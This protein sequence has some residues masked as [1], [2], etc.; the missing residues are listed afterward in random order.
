MEH[1]FCVEVATKHGIEKAIILKNLE[2]WIRKN[3]ANNKHYH[4]G[5]FWTYNSYSAFS[6]LFPYIKE[7]RIGNILRE[8]EVEGLIK[9]GNYNK[10][11]YDRTKWYSI[12]SLDFKQKLDLSNK[13]I[14][15]NPKSDNGN[16]ESGR[17]IPDNKP[18]NKHIK[19]QHVHEDS[20]NSG[21][22]AS[23][24]KKNNAN[25]TTNTEVLSI[26]DQIISLRGKK[27][28]VRNKEGFKLILIRDYKKNPSQLKKWTDEILI[29]ESIAKKKEAIRKRDEDEILIS[30]EVKNKRKKLVLKAQDI[31]FKL[32]ECQRRSVM[33]KAR[34]EASELFKNPPQSIID[35]IFS[36]LILDRTKV[37][38][39]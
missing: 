22:A 9:A 2:F 8:M 31:A 5:L 19:Q 26:I 32:P 11:S 14:I 16:T 20:F 3:K 10:S 39:R 34:L 6:E 23:N 30:N 38:T 35:E 12:P 1:S 25:T 17:P 13:G 37:L 28:V 24:F 15:H 29:S 21:A 4:D 18:D 36:R 33:D 27:S 7:K